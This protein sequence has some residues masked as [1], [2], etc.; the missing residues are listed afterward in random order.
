[1]RR[2]TLVT[3]TLPE[4]PKNPAWEE[5]NHKRMAGILSLI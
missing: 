1:M 4:L 5:P 3:V 2:I